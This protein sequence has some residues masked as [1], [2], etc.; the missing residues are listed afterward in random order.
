[1]SALKL[2]N[3]PVSTLETKTEESSVVLSAANYA[4]E[5]IRPHGLIEMDGEEPDIPNGLINFKNLAQDA[6]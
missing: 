4:V 6:G 5:R 3:W 1:M 2:R